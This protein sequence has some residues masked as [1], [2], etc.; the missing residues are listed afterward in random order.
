MKEPD[1]M[2]SFTSARL[3]PR[4]TAPVPAAPRRSQPLQGSAVRTRFCGH[5]RAASGAPRAAQ[6]G[7]C[8]RAESPGTA[9]AAHVV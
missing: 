6:R 4:A 5:R 8:R 1:E 9:R 7:N 3:A 2:G